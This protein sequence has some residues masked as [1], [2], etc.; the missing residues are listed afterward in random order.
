M[1]ASVPLDWQLHDTYFIVAHLHYVL[2]GGSVFPLLGS[3]F[4][5]WPKITG[6]MLNETLGKLSFWLVFIGFNLTFFPMHQLGLQ[7][8][9][10]RIYTYKPETGWTGLNQLATAGTFIILAALLVFGFDLLRSLRQK[11]D[12]PDNPWEGDTLEWSVPSPAPGYNYHH[13]PVVEGRYALWDRSD[14]MP[15]VS[16]LA[17][18]CREVLVTSVRDAEPEHRHQ[19][20]SSSI[21]PFMMAIATAVTFG[22]ALFTPWAF[23][24]GGFMALLAGIGWFWPKKETGIY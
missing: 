24:I 9:T 7:G 16:G 8:M 19:L 12:V 17:Y 11:P 22:G 1:T 5:W 13:I 20:P 18:D 3:I 14:P 23:V 21:W 6:R 10:R 15:V 4:Y 2:I